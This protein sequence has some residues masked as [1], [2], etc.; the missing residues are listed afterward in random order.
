MDKGRKADPFILGMIVIAGLTWGVY[1]FIDTQLVRASDMQQVQQTLQSTQKSIEKTNVRIDISIL[2][3]ERNELI[4]SLF[5]LKRLMNPS[6]KDKEFQFYLEK[7]IKEIEDQL[8]VL[9]WT[10]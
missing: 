8:K 6:E 7:R 1:T 5:E 3:A 2:K 10:E 4:K 9:Q